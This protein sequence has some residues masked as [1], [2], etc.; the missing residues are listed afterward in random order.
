MK[1]RLLAKI[2]QC[3][4]PS[5]CRRQRRG[6]LRVTIISPV[7]F[8]VHQ[9][10]VH[11]GVQSFLYLCRHACE[12]DH[13]TPVAYT[14]YLK[15]MRTQPP[16]NGFHIRISWAKLSPEFVGREPFVVT[17]GSFVVLIVKQ[18]VQCCLL[19]RAALQDEQHSL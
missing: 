2:M 18:L 17:R 14:I 6:N 12:L 10:F 5:D 8:P 16:T 3:P 15:A 4:H 9:I 11:L 7:L 13:R 19:F 1:S